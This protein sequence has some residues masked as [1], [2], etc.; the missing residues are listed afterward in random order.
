MS[1]SLWP[2]GL[3]H[4]R[5][6]CPSP[7]PGACSYSCPLNG[8]CH[9]TISSSV[10]PFSCLQSCP[11]SGSFPMSHFFASGGQN[12]GASASASVLPM[13]IQ[14]W[15]PLGWTG[16]ISLQSKGFSRVFSN[17][18]VQKH[19]FFCAQLSLWSSSQH[20]Y[21]TTGKT[22]ASTRQTFDGKVM[23][24]LLNMLSR[25]DIA[26]LPKSKRLLISWL[27]SPSAVILEPN[28]IKSVTVS[29]VSHLFA[30]KWWDWMPWSSFFECW[31]LSQ[32]FHSPLSLSSRG[33]LVPLRFL[34]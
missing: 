2:H 4:A 29:V 32:F 10:V 16:L 22:I 28:K 24:L 5:L 23:S 7:T 20:P 11:A 12:I 34:P 17:T 25:L 6:P 31:V 9:S 21:M 26:F 3:Q 14:D 1:D 30:M 15:F 8:R 33:S 19:Q 13:N 27:Q 18:T